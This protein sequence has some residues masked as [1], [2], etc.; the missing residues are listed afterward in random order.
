MEGGYNEFYRKYRNL[1]TT[2]CYLKEA[3]PSFMA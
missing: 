2:G 1:T 3:E